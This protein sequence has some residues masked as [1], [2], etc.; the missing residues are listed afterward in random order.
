[1]II[2]NQINKL[3]KINYKKILNM[4]KGGGFST[5]RETGTDHNR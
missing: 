5:N 1:M 3:S 2:N 4:K